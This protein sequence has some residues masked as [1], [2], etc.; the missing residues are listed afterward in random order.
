MLSAESYKKGLIEL[1][2]ERQSFYTKKV[3]NRMPET[4]SRS[5]FLKKF[6][7]FFCFRMQED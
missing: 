2:E 7:L 6:S 3:S 1:L 4:R 5:T